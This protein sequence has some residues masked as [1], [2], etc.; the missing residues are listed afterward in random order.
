MK[1]L[2][3][4][5]ILIILSPS[6]HSTRFCLSREWPPKIAESF[7]RNRQQE[8]IKFTLLPS[9]MA[10]LC[11]NSSYCSIIQSQVFHLPDSK[12]FQGRSG[13]TAICYS[14]GQ[15]YNTPPKIS[16]QERIKS[17]HVQNIC[18]LKNLRGETD[19]KIHSLIL[20]ACWCFTI[21]PLGIFC[22]T[23]EYSI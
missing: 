5:F 10:T 6:A 16:V 20:S 22:V 18:F 4:C 12:L 11:W 9:G 21:P 14:Q 7:S 15:A 2:N 13:G 17:L 19:F 8:I 3:S 23:M 1:V